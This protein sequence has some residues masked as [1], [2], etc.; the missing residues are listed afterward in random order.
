MENNRNELK[1][2]LVLSYINLIIGNLIPLM[3][4]PIMLSLLGQNEYGLY[5][6]SSTITGY[7]GLISMGIGSAVTRYLIKANKEGGQHAEENM[8]GMFLIIFRIIAFTSICVG[9]VILYFLPTFY[10]N[11]L[12]T[13]EM[14]RMKIL[15]FIMVLNMAISFILSPYISIVTSHEKFIFYHTINIISTCV[16]PIVNLAILYI[17]YKSVGM[18]VSSLSIIVLTRFM[19]YVYLKRSLK[20]KPRYDNMPT[21][22]LKEIFI[23]SFWVFIGNIVGQLYNATD[24]VMI[25][26]IPSLATVGVAIYSVGNV[27]NGVIISISTNLTNMLVPKVNKMIFSETNNQELTD[28]CIRV[29]RLQG[30]IVCLIVGGFIVFGRPFIHYY[31]GDEYRQ[32]YDVALW[33]MIPHVIPLLQSNCLSVVLARNL[34]KFRS[35][36]YL[37]IAILNVIGTWFLLPYYGIIGAACMSG[38]ALILGQWFTMNWYYHKVVG[39]DMIYFWKKNLPQLLLS[40]ILST[41]FILSATYIDYYNIQTLI[42]S[43]C[44]YTILYA[45]SSWFIV[46]NP[47]EKHLV[48]SMLVKINRK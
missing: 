7:L 4:T 29:G 33:V 24:T 11:S 3:F 30:Y 8:F 39:L 20:F 22:I 37:I 45:I 44:V 32:G 25:G 5:K 31:V 1:V 6:L 41:L 40:I 18:A 27:F 36:T 19:Y 28:L 21:S 46:F 38:I 10:G 12:S 47:Y 9:L 15:V 17:G 43:I 26:A 23:F 14:S 42:I 34:H 48:T 35:L 2:G 16:V 13:Y